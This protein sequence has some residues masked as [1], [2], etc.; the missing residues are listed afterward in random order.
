MNPHTVA[1]NASGEPTVLAYLRSRAA[2]PRQSV[3]A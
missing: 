1:F 2:G 3:Y